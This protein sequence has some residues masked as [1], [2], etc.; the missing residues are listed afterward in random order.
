ML[1]RLEWELEQRK[2][3]AGKLKDAQTSKE[4]ISQEIRSKEDYLD[5][6][7]PKLSS[8]LEA[9]RPVQNY[10]KMPYDE[11]REQHQTARHLPM[12]LYVLYM[13]AG[14]YQ[15]A[16]D[17][18]LKV[19]IDG[20][21]NA[22]K[23][24]DL[25][26]LE[27]DDDSDSDQEGEEQEKRNSKRRRKTVE[28]R[29]S[30]KKQKVIRK[31]PLSVVLE[32]NCKDGSVL[33]LTFYFLHALN[34]ITVGVK[35]IP[36]KEVVTN[37]VT[38]GDLLSPQS[39]LDEL[40]PDDHGD[41]T[42]NP[43]NQYELARYGMGDFG[44]YV[45]QVG[46]PYMW[47]QW[48]GGLQFLDHVEAEPS[49]SLSSIRPK[50]SISATYMQQTIKRLRQRLKARLGLLQQLAS[51]ERG[52]VPCTGPVMKKFPVKIISQLVSW[53]RVT[54]DDVSILPYASTLINTG[55]IKR[56]D[57]VFMAV[58]ERGSAKLTAHV[59]VSVDY[60]EVVPLFMTSISW[61]TQRTAATDIHVKEME[62]E[63]NIH[64]EELVVD[65]SHDQL[66]SNQLQRLLVC[67]DVYLETEVLDVSAPV[68]IPKEKVIPRASRWAQG[69]AKPYKYI[70]ELAIF[71][72]R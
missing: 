20:D 5:T 66:L 68:E 62:E 10:L 71:T 38:G 6:L 13:Q 65:K 36:G 37:S 56:N 27:P 44:Q 17:Q 51:L 15:Q 19:T 18:F 39:V 9:T 43:A 24:F 69:E 40:Y 14:A 25:G 52:I 45:A 8:I 49:S 4:K 48:L 67:F 46:R 47:A 33:H 72:Q 42:P 3:L 53:K 41:T 22:A 58:L 59:I 29:L 2:E 1:S 60:P 54:Y 28:A 32:I 61:H 7:Q 12:P 31:H 34:I 50:T 64:Y 63:V 57:L 11:I 21:V 23:S 55:F 30:D 16:C 26:A 70:P 35:V